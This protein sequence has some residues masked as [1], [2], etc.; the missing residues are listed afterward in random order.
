MFWLFAYL[1]ILKSEPLHNSTKIQVSWIMMSR[2][3]FQKKYVLVKSNIFQILKWWNRN[4]RIAKLRLIE[5]VQSYRTST[6]K[7]WHQDM[8]YLNFRLFRFYSRFGLYFIGRDMIYFLLTFNRC[9]AKIWL[10]R[11][12]DVTS[13][14][15]L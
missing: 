6:N 9:L 8:I 10:V 14:L 4:K 3:F 2:L 7:V 15:W 11:H 12:N 1:D 5:P 13:L